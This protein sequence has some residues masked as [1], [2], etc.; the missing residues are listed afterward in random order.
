MSKPPKSADRFLSWFCRNELLEEVRGDLHEY[1]Y[2][3]VEDHGPFRARCIYWFHVL[4]FL[5]PFAFKKLNNRSTDHIMLKNNIKVSWRNMMKHKRFSSV[6]LFGLAMGIASSLF[7]MAYVLDEMKVDQHHPNKQRVQRVNTDLDTGDSNMQ[8]SVAS[9]ALGPAMLNNFPEVQAFLRLTKPWSPLLVKNK[10]KRDYESQVIYADSDFFKFFEYNLQSGNNETLLD[11]PGKVVLTASLAKK[12]FGNGNPIGQ[13]LEIKDLPYLVTAVLANEQV[14]S[15]LTFDM[16]ISF[17]SWTREFTTTETNWGWSPTN[18]YV[19]L[20]KNANAQN[21][22]QQLPAFV[23]KYMASQAQEVQ[24]DLSL[25]PLADLYFNPTRLG[26]I[27]R[28]GNRKQLY[29]LISAA[30]LI[31]VLAISNFINLSSARAA[32]RMKEVGVRKVVGAHRKQLTFQFFTESVLYAVL[33]ALLAMALVILFWEPFL[34]L[35]N[36]DIDLGSFMSLQNVAVVIAAVLLIGLLA[37]AY[38]A[39]LLSSFKPIDALKSRS[40]RGGHIASAR[41]VMLTFQFF[42]SIGLLIISLTM[43]KQFLLIENRELGFYKGETLVV[44]LGQSQ[45]AIRKY[46]LIKNELLATGYLSGVSFSSHVPGDKPHSITTEMNKAGE[47]LN[48]EIWLNI[49]DHDF[50]DNYGLKMLAGRSFSKSMVADTVGSVILNERALETFGISSPEEALGLM[51]SQWGRQGKAIGVVQD[52]NQESLHN[53]I[54]PMSFQ[55]WPAQFQKASLRI[56]TKNLAIALPAIERAW[57]DLTNS[58]FNYAFLD[59]RLGALYAADQRFGKIFRFFTLLSLTITFLG[60]VSFAAF[61]VRLK[62][63]EMAIRKVLGAAPY[64]L[65]IRLTSQFW[66]PA[67]IALFISI[68]PSYLFLKDWLEQFAYQIDM[69]PGSLL[70]PVIILIGV[71]ALT[72]SIQGF[73]A[74][75]E[76]P[77]K[78]LRNE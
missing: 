33:S 45:E 24:L 65:M 54:S 68:V 57:Q 58:P 75:R 56:S 25:S 71:V 1:F 70:L 36:K 37:G 10:N 22:E 15:H 34:R 13:Q 44:D 77:I 8:L 43:W 61:V 72:L 41:K 40:L 32:E 28:N 2:I 74:I 38:P 6:H 69:G 4:H 53:E 51:V 16:L 67:T 14:P 20:A 35:I 7:I 39:L 5:R 78:H 23:E 47:Q 11:G 59:D 48:A 21:L 52:F 66:L 63:K 3:A 29:L 64:L 26:D 30:L 73:G 27:G 17:A 42:I 50:I 46:Q 19:L 76:N 62:M 55:V 31:I 49:V 18:T 9:G 12:Y 60:L